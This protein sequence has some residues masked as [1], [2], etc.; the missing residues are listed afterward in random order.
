MPD[1]RNVCIQPLADGY[2]VR[3]EKDGRL[4]EEFTTR[5]PLSLVEK[6]ARVR[7]RDA[8]ERLGD[9]LAYAGLAEM[10][11]RR[12]LSLSGLRVLDVGCRYGSSSLAASRLGARQV[13]GIDISHEPLAI[14]RMIL[15]ELEGHPDLRGSAQVAF[16]C[17]APGQPLPFAAASF[18][19]VLCNAVFE[20][21]PP[22][23]RPAMVREL[24]RLLR[25][26]GYLLIHE[27]PNRWWPRD[28]H[29]TKLWL[30]P[31]LPRPLVQVEADL[32]CHRF[33]HEQVHNWNY[34]L[35]AG[36]RGVSYPEIAHHAPGHDSTLDRRADDIRGYFDLMLRQYHSPRQRAMNRLYRFLCR[37]LEWI[38]C[39]PLRLPNTTVI[40]NLYMAL[41]KTG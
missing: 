4:H 18:D 40:P 20:H 25:P 35:T 28:T 33:T 31:Y 32:F 10:L 26:G 8:F 27:T 19:A 2:R 6:L 16:A 17:I 30:V 24:W 36:V 23:Q 12:K 37:V 11:E 38:I 7:G 9:P 5:L 14:G 29:T 15:G 3:I 22:A 13:V 34:M 39:K 21:V 41:R 1:S